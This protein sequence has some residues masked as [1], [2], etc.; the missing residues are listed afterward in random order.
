MQRTLLTPQLV[1]D[2][3]RDRK[4]MQ[5]VQRLQQL[6]PIAPGISIRMKLLNQDSWTLGECTKKLAKRSHLVIVKGQM[7]MRYVMDLN[8]CPL[9]PACETTMHLPACETTMHLPSRGTWKTLSGGYPTTLVAFRAG[10]N[11]TKS[12]QLQLGL[13]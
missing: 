10:S 12:L 3:P 6:A 9:L 5:D 1:V 4:A 7:Y 8:K 2:I 13:L 11:Y